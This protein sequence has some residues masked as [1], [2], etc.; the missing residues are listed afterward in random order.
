M[1]RGAGPVPAPTDYAS[2]FTACFDAHYR[3]VFQR[4]VDQA[5]QFVV[6]ANPPCGGAVVEL[7][8]GSGRIT[9]DGGLADRVG[10]RG[11]LLATDPS[12]AQLEVLQTRLGTVD[13]PWVRLLRA[14]AET[15]P[16]ASSCVDMAIGSTFLHFTD[17]ARVMREV[18][19]ILRPGGRL[20]LAAP[21]PFRWPPFWED[22]LEPVAAEARR[23]R[24][25]AR[26]WAVPEEEVLAATAAAGLEVERADQM[27]DYGDAPTYAVA[28]ASVRQTHTVALMLPGA[29]TDRLAAVEEEVFRRIAERWDAYT[30]AERGGS[31]VNLH[32]V[33]RK[34]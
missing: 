13:I 20:A 23:L 1:S 14:P 25:A 30:E 5:K 32:L 7:G 27:A 6:F 22:V 16:V 8:A 29:P 15:L 12:V 26:H 9:L 10:P 34:P 11:Q 3:A 19:R 28:Q 31:F 33:A 17:P 21:L 4:A 24:I 2:R 18:A